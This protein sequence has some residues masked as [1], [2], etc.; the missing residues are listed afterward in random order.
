[1]KFTL[2]TNPVSSSSSDAG[3]K[4]ALPQRP[5][6]ATEETGESQMSVYIRFAN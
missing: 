1:M 4:R 5:Q 3:S 2:Q 6:R